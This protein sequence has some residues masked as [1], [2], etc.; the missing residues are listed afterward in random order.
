MRI[1]EKNK[2]NFFEEEVWKYFGGKSTL[3]GYI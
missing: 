2:N 3:S 1:V